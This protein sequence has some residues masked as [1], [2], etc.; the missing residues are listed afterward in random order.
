MSINRE[1]RANICAIIYVVDIVSATTRERESKGSEGGGGGSVDG[2]ID[3]SNPVKKKF[4]HMP[5]N[6]DSRINNNPMPNACQPAMRV[7]GFISS[8]HVSLFF[9]I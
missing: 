1:L 8:I 6:P 9:I 5:V 3:I 4:P 7:K 2:N